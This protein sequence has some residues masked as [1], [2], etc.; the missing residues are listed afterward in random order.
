MK[1]K[2]EHACLG[3]LWKLIVCFLL[4]FLLFLLLPIQ[5]GIG[6]FLWTFTPGQ[7]QKLEFNL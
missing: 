2:R 3:I 5:L 6:C 7:L 4:V 1:R